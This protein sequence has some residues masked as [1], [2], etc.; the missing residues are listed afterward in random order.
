[1][2]TKRLDYLP[3][4][5]LFARIVQYGSLSGAAKHSGLS[6]SAVSK[7]LSALEEKLGVRLLQ[8]STRNVRLTEAGK[9]IHSEA[10]RV[11]EAFESVETLS[12]EMQGE[13]NGYLKVSCSTG[14]GR[15]HLVPLI[16]QFNALYP[17]VHVHLMLEDR[18]VDLIDEQI[19]VAIRVGHLPNSSLIALRLGE[20][21][22][23]VCASPG[24]LA[25][26]GTPKQPKD[27]L[28]HNCLCYRNGQSSFDNWLFNSNAGEER[29]AIKGAL[30]VND[31]TALVQA[32]E[33]DQ[34]I[35]WVDKNSLGDALEQGR[36]VQILQD[37]ALGVGY[38]IY[39][40]YPARRHMPIKTRVFVDFLAEHFAPRMRYK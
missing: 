17:K 14:I 28:Q 15:V 12:D 6:R 36:L 32:A 5:V 23:A 27:L 38:P 39:A 18:F 40:L 35:V 26:N 21:A 1:M 31:S 8:R 25:K 20:M 16:K 33:D 34:G 37:Y 2:T 13:V 11:L 30:S 4:L 24:Y 19:D 7:Q 29:I 10:C 22:W 3:A 9:Q